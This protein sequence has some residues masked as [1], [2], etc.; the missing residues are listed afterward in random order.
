VNAESAYL[1][2]HAL[3]RDA[4]YHLPADRARRPNSPC[5]MQSA[6]VSPPEPDADRESPPRRFHELGAAQLGDFRHAF[7]CSVIEGIPSSFRLAWTLAMSRPV[8]RLTSRS[9][10]V[11]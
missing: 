8:M 10:T 7:F 4:A 3:L 9:E 11:P 6:P 5:E 2:R 1:F